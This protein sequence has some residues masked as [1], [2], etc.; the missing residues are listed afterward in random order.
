M[1]SRVWWQT[2]S[3]VLVGVLLALAVHYVFLKALDVLVL[4]LLGLL[5]AYILDPLLDLL[6]GWGWKRA[7]A[8]WTVTL[9]F[10]VVVAGTGVLV[11]PGIVLQVQDAASHWQEYSLKAQ[12]TYDFW[13][14]EIETYATR[15]FPTVDVMPYLDAKV[16]EANQW[17]QAH[18]PAFLQWVSGKLIASL[19][20]IGL[21]AL[22]ILISFH[23]M[24]VIDPLRRTVRAY[25]PQQAD[26]EVGSLTKQINAML[27]QYL[28][29]I[30]IVSV[31]VGITATVALWVLSLLF[32]TKYALIL[33]VV[34]GVTY[35]V[36]YVGPVLSAVGAG[37]FGYVTAESGSP[38]LSGLIALLAMVGLNQIYD[39]VIAP[40]IVGQ[41]VGLHPLLV[42]FSIM[43]GLSLLGIWGVILAMPV[44]ASIKIILARWL[45]I[46]TI[47]FTAPSPRRKLEIDLPAS[48][49]L[50]GHRV[51]QIGHGL[52]TKLHHEKAAEV[53]AGEDVATEGEAG[54][55]EKPDEGK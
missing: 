4:F 7:L 28:R 51:S 2:V 6:E 16:L 8:V 41:R 21:F 36:P 25:L 50:V 14:G 42:L 48:I 3:A 39:N 43:I 11:V 33:G 1:S 32:G 12:E 17:G 24:M 13:R 15:H 10:L 49:A 29:G 53:E 45:P 47:D 26:A 55:E 46:K 31:M 44:A 9:A 22:L 18:L 20:M 37:F 38:W 35:M 34:T 30:I 27:A 54:A 23:F 52:K 5:V 40:R 19:G